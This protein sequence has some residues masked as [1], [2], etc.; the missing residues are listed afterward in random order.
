[1]GTPTSIPPT[2]KSTAMSKAILMGVNTIT[3]IIM[4]TGSR[5]NHIITSTNTKEITG[6]TSMSTPATKPRF[7]PI[8]HK[9]LIARTGGVP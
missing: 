9:Q 1:M 6:I 7:M 2:T 3:S 4:T 8:R 5:L